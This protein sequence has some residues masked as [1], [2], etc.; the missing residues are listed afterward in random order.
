[1]LIL[2]ICRPAVAL[3]FWS[4]GFYRYIAP[5]ALAYRPSLEFRLQPVPRPAPAFS[6][7]RRHS[8]EFRLQAAPS[9]VHSLE[10]RL[11]PVPKPAPDFSGQRR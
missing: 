6:G 1:M 7:Q 8:L 3:D 4:P 10:F 9:A 2:G 11:Q 5:M